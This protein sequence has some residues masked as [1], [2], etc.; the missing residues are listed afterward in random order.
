MT[1]RKG[2]EDT[3][4]LQNKWPHNRLKH[5]SE[6]SIMCTMPN[7]FNLGILD[8]PRPSLQHGA[9][10]RQIPEAYIPN[11]VLFVWF[12]MWDEA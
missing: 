6:L 3:G 2:T 10:T 1:D 11:G 8:S 12:W 5:F 9:G 7:W 4:S